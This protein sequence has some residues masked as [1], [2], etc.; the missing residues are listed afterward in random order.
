[1]PPCPPAPQADILA[2]VTWVDGAGIVHTSTRDSDAGRALVSG[3]GVAGIVTELLLQL[4]GPGRTA[5]D[6]RFKKSDKQL[7]GDIQEL[8]KVC[9]GAVCCARACVRSCSC[10]ATRVSNMG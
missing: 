1:M 10:G 6:T 7:A 4:K 8:L 3:L 5:F 2:E 9:C